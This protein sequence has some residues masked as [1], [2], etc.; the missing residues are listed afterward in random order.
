MQTLWL[1]IQNVLWNVFNRPSIT[2]IVDILI[3]AFLLYELLMLTRETRASAVLKGLVM[4]VLASWISDLLGL[5]ALNWILLNIVNN[6]AVVLVILFQPELRKA[7]EQIGRGA[8]RDTSRVTDHEENEQIVREISNCLL[9]LS[10]RRVGALIVFE[11]R[12]GLKDIIETG[13]ALNSRISSALLENIFEPNTPLHDGAVVIRGNQIMAA[14]CFLTLSE[15][16]S[17]S[18]E[19]GTRHRAALGITE[20]TDAITLIVS[21]ET[22]IISMAKEGRLTR[23]L[24]R[25]SLE[26]VLLSMY[27]QKDSS[28]WSALMEKTRRRKGGAE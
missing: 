10:R 17:I 27:H 28:L 13:T 23:H 19:L 18:R 14:G 12:I 21:E 22:G 24:D 8:I 7:L 1:Q 11:Q 3:V 20:T 26:Q 2:D 16:K 4:L 9:S 25:M 6:G 15:G 5:T